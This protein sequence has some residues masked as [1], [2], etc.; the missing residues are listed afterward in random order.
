MRIREAQ[1]KALQERQVK[2]GFGQPR[3]TVLLPQVTAEETQ[4]GQLQGRTD[5]ETSEDT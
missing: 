3:E 1:L 4:R 2:A 5:S